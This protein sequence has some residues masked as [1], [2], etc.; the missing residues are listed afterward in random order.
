MKSRFRFCLSKAAV[1]FTGAK[2]VLGCRPNGLL[3]GV[4]DA[5]R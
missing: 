5:V 2:T 1:K 4:A 3:D